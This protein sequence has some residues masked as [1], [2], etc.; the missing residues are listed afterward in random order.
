MNHRDGIH[1]QEYHLEA[2]IIGITMAT[3]T[4]IK[5]KSTALFFRKTSFETEIPQFVPFSSFFFGERKLQG[6]QFDDKKL[7][8]T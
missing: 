8:D 4:V 1:K 5:I 3:I 2:K 6:L 7:M